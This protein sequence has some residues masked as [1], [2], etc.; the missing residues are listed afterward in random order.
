MFRPVLTVFI[1]SV[2]NRPNLDCCSQRPSQ[3]HCGQRPSLTFPD[4]CC[5]MSRF[6]KW[7]FTKL[8][9][10]VK[11]HFKWVRSDCDVQGFGGAEEHCIIDRHICHIPFRRNFPF[12]RKDNSFFNVV[13]LYR[14]E[15]V[16]RTVFFVVLS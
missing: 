13:V 7:C 15:F 14:H 10:N 11:C 4:F 5:L 9:K 2:K 12:V 16:Q 8:L 6:V 1:A 3:L